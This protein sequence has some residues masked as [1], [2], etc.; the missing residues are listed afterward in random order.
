[1]T[2]TTTF[3]VLMLIVGAGALQ[4]DDW[5]EFRGEGRLGVW[6]ETGILETFPEGGL[7]VRWRT[8][9]HHGFSGPSVADGRIF[10]TDFERG[11]GL[12]GT[13]RL[14]ALDEQTPEK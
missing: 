6:T 7:D 12:E 8:P 13:E 4:A 5:P 11:R 1:M 14:L 9:L 10:I 2:K 3:I